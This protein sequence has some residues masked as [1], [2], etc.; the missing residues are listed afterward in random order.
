MDVLV[1]DNGISNLLS[2][3]RAIEHVGHK[4]IVTQDC[5]ANGDISHM[6]LPGVGAFD[7]AMIKMKQSQADLRVK[8]FVSRGGCLLGVC[9]GMQVLFDSSSESS[10][11]G[12][13][14]L[15][16]IE[17]N[18]RYLPSPNRVLGETMPNM[19]WKDV[20]MVNRQ[21]FFK[22]LTTPM[23][24]YFVHSYHCL[25]KNSDAVSMT[26]EFGNQD[27]CAG[28]TAGNVH[29]VQFHPEKS[30]ELGLRLLKKFIE[31]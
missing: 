18:V 7:T 19:G 24:F 12:E 9:L 20:K 28:V 5:I 11:S 2:M 15:G 27:I 13:R 30:G 29:G 23:Q 16:L 14:G 26:I 17:G 22:D 21:N 10:N 3:I 1:Y 31:Y 25:P 8:E 6:I 4:P